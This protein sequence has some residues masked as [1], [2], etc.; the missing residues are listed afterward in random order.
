MI[1]GKPKVAN[2]EA[3]MIK[4]GLT[5]EDKERLA[6]EHPYPEMDLSFESDYEEDVQL[7]TQ[8]A[9][10]ETLKSV[11]EWGNNICCQ[12][13]HIE[14]GTLFQKARIQRKKCPE[15]WQIL[16]SLAEGENVESDE[17]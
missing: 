3:T 12:H 8:A 7:L 16:Q 10:H 11:V 1:R 15:C 2:L 9:S 5:S 4:I 14:P 6:K 17:K 13:K